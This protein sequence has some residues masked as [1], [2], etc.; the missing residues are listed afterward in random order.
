MHSINWAEE[1]QSLNAAGSIA[2]EA[3]FVASLEARLAELPSPSSV[4]PEAAAAAALDA[5]SLEAAP[6]TADLVQV[7]ERSLNRWQGH[8]PA[9]VDD[10]Q[11]HPAQIAA[12][13][14]ELSPLVELA[15]QID[16]LP[17][18]DIAATSPDLDF[19][20]GLEDRLAEL[21][22]PRSLQA[23]AP[24]VGLGTF[25]FRRLWRSTAFMAA[26]AAAVLIFFGAGLSYA[27]ADALPGDAL[28]PIKRISEQ[29]RLLLAPDGD[30]VGVYL[31]LA[32]T[33]LFEASAVP[34]EAG[35]NLADF[36]KNV[37]AALVTIDHSIAAGADRD[38]LAPPLLEWLLGARD[39]LVRM[40]SD[41][42]PIAWRAALALVD[43]AILAL[44]DGR[45]LSLAPVPRLD[46]GSDDLQLLASIQPFGRWHE[47]SLE[48]AAPEAPPPVSLALAQPKP[49]IDIA[50]EAG[51]VLESQ[52]APLVV[53][54]PVPE[55]EDQ[56]DRDQDSDPEESQDPAIDP[57][58]GEP[59]LDPVAIEIVPATATSVPDPAQPTQVPTAVPAASILSMSCSPSKIVEAGESACH[60]EI[61]NPGNQDLDYEWSV[62]PMD[63]EMLDAD[64]PRATFVA[65][66]F[67]SGFGT[68][69][70]IVIRITIRD[71]ES[72]EKL[73]DHET[74]VEVIPAGLHMQDIVDH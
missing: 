4:R 48:R 60:V 45:P 56:D 38:R 66:V 39:H 7:L 61:D 50:A 70:E 73:D 9:G 64:Q 62:P 57:S 54:A 18:M 44:Q 35:Q 51:A 47:Q 26:T 6:S 69:F 31:G 65:P 43:E 74:L 23:E 21:P 33:R 63:G 11:L 53:S 20:K 5:E 27:S 8:A 3:E 42:P 17:E 14:S 28:Y 16:G 36:S 67:P 25:V 58:E 72:N 29:A 12:A 41:M 59:K 40:R 55:D 68:K 24:T 32:E 2:P 34:D 71:A 19:V 30:R 1:L 49:K 52:P 15:A 37:T 10:M 13:E 22:T 46:Q